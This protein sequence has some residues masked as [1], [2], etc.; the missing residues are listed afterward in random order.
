MIH[1]TLYIIQTR[2]TNRTRRRLKL[3]TPCTYIHSEY[4]STREIGRDIFDLYTDSCTKQ[5]QPGR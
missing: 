1:D 5:V 3:G 2:R 4:S